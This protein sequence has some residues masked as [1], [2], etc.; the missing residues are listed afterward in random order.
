MTAATPE[1]EFV[2][3]PAEK[4]EVASDAFSGQ[5]AVEHKGSGPIKVKTFRHDAF[6]YTVFSVH[7]RHYGAQKAEVEAWR[8]V[9]ASLYPGETTQRYHDKEAIEAGLRQRGD[10]TGLVVLVRGQR[11]VCAQRVLFYQDLPATAPLS[12]AEAEAYDRNESG[13]GWRALWYAG[14]TPTWHTLRGHPV[15]RYCCHSTLGHAHTVLFWRHESRIEE[16]SLD[17]EVILDPSTGRAMQPNAVVTPEAGQLS[18]F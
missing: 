10:Y 3:V 18:L 7:Y 8:L 12:R 6:L 2:L 1:N 4:W 11:M 14:A 9:P 5:L 15:A 17:I 13:Y 16:M